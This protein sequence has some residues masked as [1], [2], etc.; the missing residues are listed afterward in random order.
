MADKLEEERER[1]QEEH[2]QFLLGESNMRPRIAPH[3]DETYIT[4]RVVK[5]IGYAITPS[6]KNLIRWAV[7]I[8]RRAMQEK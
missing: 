8:T 2:Y 6:E 3:P 5:S 4:N 7:R 1:E